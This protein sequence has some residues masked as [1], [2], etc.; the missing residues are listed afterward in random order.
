MKKLVLLMALVCLV[1]VGVNKPADAALD[2]QPVSVFGAG[3]GGGYAWCKVKF[4][5]VIGQTPTPQFFTMYF[6]PDQNSNI[7]LATAMTAMSN[8]GGGRAYFDPDTAVNYQF[9]TYLE[10]DNTI[11]VP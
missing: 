1:M 11:T 9:L 5:K 8:G 10:A 6:L 7:F 2:W 3:T 4:I